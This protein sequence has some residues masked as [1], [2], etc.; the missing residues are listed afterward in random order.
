MNDLALVL[1]VFAACAVEAVEALTIVLAAGAGRHW[2]SAFQGAAAALLGL[3]V[4]VAALGPAVERIPIDGLRLGVGIVLLLF[5]LRW[6]RKA[7]LRASGRK[8]LRDEAAAYDRALAVGRAA[9]GGGRGRV[10]DWYAFSLS[11]KGV[12]IEGLEVAF[13]VVTF[14]GTQRNVPLASVGAVA[15]VLAVA[16]VGFAVRAPLARVPENTLKFAVGVVLTAFGVFWTAEGAGASWPGADAALLVL[17]PGVLLLALGCAAALRRT[18][19][20]A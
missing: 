15:A 19:P 9:A 5:G 4:T 11:F 13:I 10:R 7:V 3:A 6:L 17:I 16:G 20:A 14:G 2:P 1:T 8:A 18:T 12:F